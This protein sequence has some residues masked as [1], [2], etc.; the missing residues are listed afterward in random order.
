MK[1]YSVFIIILLMFLYN[2]CD[3]KT[4]PDLLISIERVKYVD[5]N[6]DGRYDIIYLNVMLTET[7]GLDLNIE[8]YMN[9]VYDSND[10]LI[11]KYAEN[12][13]P[14]YKITGF[15]LYTFTNI[16][17]NLRYNNRKSSKYK[18]TIYYNSNGKSY[19]NSKKIKI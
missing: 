11:Y 14:V 2:K 5:T 7:K 18:F 15:G 3:K 10:T 12:N 9:E 1:K 13:P 17:I 16:K 6:G 4:T 8:Q 19:K